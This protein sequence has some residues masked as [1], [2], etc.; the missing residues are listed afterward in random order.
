[1]LEHEPE[2]GGLS[3]VI[4]AAAAV[5]LVAA[6]PENQDCALP[7][8]AAGLIEEGLDIMR[9]NPAL[10]SVKQDE[11]RRAGRVVVVMQVNEISVR[12]LESLQARAVKNLAPEKFSP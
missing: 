10:Q 4:K 9:A 12:R 6:G 11:Q 8:A 7:S 2:V 1:M 3:R 5:G